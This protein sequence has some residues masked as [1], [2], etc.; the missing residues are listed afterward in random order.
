MPVIDGDGRTLTGATLGST[1]A[2]SVLVRKVFADPCSP[3]I[4]NMGISAA[5]SHATARPWSFWFG[6]LRSE[7]NCSIELPRCGTGSGNR[8]VGR[9]KRLGG[10]GSRPAIPPVLSLQL[11]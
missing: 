3:D 9:R 2:Q 1:S 10:K 4:A 6:R 8:P 5:Q 11:G 7:P